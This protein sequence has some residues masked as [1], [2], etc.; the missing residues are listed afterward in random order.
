MKKMLL[1]AIILLL[2]LVQAAADITVK[3]AYTN[4]YP[5]E[6]GSSFILGIEVLN[7]GDETAK[8]LSVVVSPNSP[9]AV[10]DK[11]SDFISSL[12]SGSIRIVEYKMFVD[13][14]AVSSTY[15]IPVHIK[16]S[17][18]N[19][20]TRNLIVRVQGKPNIGYVDVPNFSVS[21]GE[22][23]TMQVEI[24]NL[25]SGTAKRVVATLTSLNDNI[26]TVFSGGSAY[27]EDIP[28]NG[29][30]SAVFQIYVNPD[31]GYGVYDSILKVTYEDEAG[32]VQTK[33]FSIGIFVTGKP[34]IKIIKVSVDK[35]KNELK[36]DVINDGNAEARGIK[37]ELMIGDSV[38]DVDYISKINS[39]KSS[40]LK[41]GIPQVKDNKVDI[42][43]SYSGANNEKHQLKQKISWQNPT[44]IN[45]IFIIV[46]IV[47][48]YFLLRNFDGKFF[49]LFKKSKK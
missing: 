49:G 8:D 15:Q 26:K 1:L 20:I 31:T 17:G 4:P 7:T 30:K 12:S 29:K 39:Q 41:F 48:A 43:I 37:G 18:S 16:Y 6:P 21:P 38:I 9:F 2:P 47:I 22:T 46:V 5:V 19:D 45:W 11:P 13:S 14:S 28:S 25:G 44:G 36:V 10:V 3:T 35:A 32:N 42:S 40:T 34:E 23:K 27:L 24:K 33:N